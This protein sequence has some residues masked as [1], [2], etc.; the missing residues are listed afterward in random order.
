MIR[1]ALHFPAAAVLTD[2][3]V[4][5]GA[6]EIHLY[7]SEASFDLKPKCRREPFGYSSWSPIRHPHA[8]LDVT[9]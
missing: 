6:L 1:Y 9:M 3:K 5:D 7:L 4:P 8:V 2:E